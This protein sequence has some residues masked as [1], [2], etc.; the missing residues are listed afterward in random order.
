MSRCEHGSCGAME[1]C[2]DKSCGYYEPAVDGRRQCSGALGFTSCLV[3][4]HS[5]AR[6]KAMERALSC[7]LDT[8]KGRFEPGHGWGWDTPTPQTMS[9]M[10]TGVKA[11][12]GAN[13]A[14]EDKEEREAQEQGA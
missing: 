3:L 10:L 11:A 5:E 14:P 6:A 12:L 2:G 1:Q 9:A 8:F 4:A 7:V 13:P